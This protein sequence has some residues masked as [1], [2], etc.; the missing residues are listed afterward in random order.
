MNGHA[1]HVTHRRKGSPNKIIVGCAKGTQ[2]FFT[3][4]VRQAIIDAAEFVGEECVVNPD[5]PNEPRGIT[6]FLAKVAREQPAIM[7]GMLA[8]LVP[9]QQT[10]GADLSDCSNI[11]PGHPLRLRLA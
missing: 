1:G 5:D 10:G 4:E 9:I 7:C 11:T 8:R 2:N 6:A 3:R